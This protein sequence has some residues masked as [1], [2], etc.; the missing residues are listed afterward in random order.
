MRILVKTAIAAGAALTLAIPAQ[1]ADNTCGV[2]SEL[3]GSMVDFMLPMTLQQVVD[4]TSGKNDALAEQMGMK[5]IS[6]LSE[7]EIMTLGTMNETDAGLISEAAGMVAIELLMTGQATTSA[8]IRNY[9]LLTCNQVGA[10]QIIA[11][12]SKMRAATAANMGQ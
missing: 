3:G 9:M 2:Y 5:M 11:N 4:L 10:S 6:N 12:Q 8:E 7:D 1:A